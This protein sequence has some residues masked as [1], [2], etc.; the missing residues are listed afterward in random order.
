MAAL[1]RAAR[2]KELIVPSPGSRKSRRFTQRSKDL[3]DEMDDA[4]TTLNERDA[5]ASIPSGFVVRMRGRTRVR[6]IVGLAAAA[7]TL[8]PSGGRSVA[9]NA[10]LTSRGTTS[11]LHA[12]SSTIATPR[13]PC[14][15]Q[16]H[17]RNLNCSC[18]AEGER[19]QRGPHITVEAL[20]PAVICTLRTRTALPARER[21]ISV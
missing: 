20:H 21:A 5:T 12:E 10:D 19:R 6:S 11:L 8:Q 17:A 2:L 3:H 13:R 9:R 16:T 1:P 18:L 7:H 15:E 14:R 4:E